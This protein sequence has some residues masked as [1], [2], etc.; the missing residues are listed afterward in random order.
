MGKIQFFSYWIDES[1]ARSRFCHISSGRKSSEHSVLRQDKEMQ[2]NSLGKKDLLS[3]T[4]Q[5]RQISSIFPQV[6]AGLSEEVPGGV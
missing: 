2:D 1:R 6:P 3:P 5:Q 4:K